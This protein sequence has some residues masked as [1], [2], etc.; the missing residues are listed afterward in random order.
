[1]AE[2]HEKA[3]RSGDEG[4][5]AFG[6]GQASDAVEKL[7][8][9]DDQASRSIKDFT[10]ASEQW[11]QDAQERA[12]G[13]AKDLSEQ[14]GRAVGAVSDTVEHNPLASLAVA[15]AAGFLLASLIKR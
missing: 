15:F 12:R 11:A 10:Q 13:I 3:E 14:G 9:L 6:F 1:M 8:P 5:T 4:K 7:R 2:K